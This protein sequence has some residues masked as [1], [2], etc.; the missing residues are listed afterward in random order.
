MLSVSGTH[1][2]SLNASNTLANLGYA[3]EGTYKVVVQDGQ[4]MVDLDKTAAD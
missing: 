3:E 4:V 1:A 2:L